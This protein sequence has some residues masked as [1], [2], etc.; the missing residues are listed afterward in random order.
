MD[1]FLQKLKD[2]GIGGFSERIPVGVGIHRNGVINESDLVQVPDIEEFPLPQIEPRP[3]IQPDV[4]RQA[5]VQSQFEI[6][7][8][9][10]QTAISTSHPSSELERLEPGR[11]FESPEELLKF[12]RALATY[13]NEEAQKI[14]WTKPIQICQEPI[15]LNM[16]IPSF[17]YCSNHLSKD[18]NFKSQSFIK[19]CSAVDE[20][21]NECQFPAQSGVG[22]CIHH[23]EK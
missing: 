21:A 15:C 12:K 8:S 10:L 14:G 17:N 23:S 20:N 5:V 3:A 19:K 16:A 18:P 9:Q 1:D 7:L 6:L 11:E 4:L 2:N 13:Y 22:L